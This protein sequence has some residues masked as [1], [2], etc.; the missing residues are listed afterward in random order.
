MLF[1]AVNDWFDDDDVSA[2]SSAVVSPI[3]D[4]YP[5]GNI[6]YHFG[7]QSTHT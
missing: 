6:T 7:R 4:T 3:D 1:G 2:N 5:G